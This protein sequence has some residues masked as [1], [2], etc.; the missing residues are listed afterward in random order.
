MDDAARVRGR[1]RVG[2]R[3]RDAQQLVQAQALPRDERVEAG[4]AHVLHDDEV[5]GAVRLDLVDRDDVR[6][7]ERGGGLRF[8][9]KAAPAACSSCIRS[10]GRTLMATSRP[11]RVSRARYTSP[12]PPAPIGA[13][14]S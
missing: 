7:V 10:A 1:E 2:H 13:S 9:E 11:S 4:A 6:M 8:L 3:H 12:I 14:T 5:D